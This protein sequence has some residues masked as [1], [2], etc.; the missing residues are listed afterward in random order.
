MHVKELLQYNHDTGIFIW[1][2]PHRKVRIG[3]I[4][5][6]IT[7]NGY[8]VITIDRIRYRA[9]RLARFYMTGEWPEN[10]IDHINRD[11][12]DNRF[13][14]LRLATRSENHAN[15]GMRIDNTSG[16][17]G[18]HWHK[19]RQKWTAHIKHNGK[20]VYLGLFESKDEAYK[21]YC[22]AANAHFGTF[23]RL[24]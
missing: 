20:T 14:N 1:A 8:R 11:R 12:D 17:K 4:A 18:V 19:Q 2:A 22:D 6:T 24:A 15:R 16:L 9:H 23:A 7:T 5:G 21:A 10:D 13:A 3:D